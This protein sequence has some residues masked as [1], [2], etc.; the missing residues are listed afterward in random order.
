[1][2]TRAPILGDL[3][4]TMW[5]GD[6]QQLDDGTQVQPLVNLLLGNPQT[7]RWQAT[8]ACRDWRSGGA[9]VVGD[10]MLIQLLLGTRAEDVE[11]YSEHSSIGVLWI[12]TWGCW[13]Y[14]CSGSNN[15]VYLQLHMGVDMSRFPDINSESEVMQEICTQ[16]SALDIC[17]NKLCP[18]GGNGGVVGWR[19]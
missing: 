7:I 5:R 2:V 4:G 10:S 13:P 19:L 14:R 12:N 1:M 8:R 15:P 11:E 16:G 17:Y 9:D 6:A 3:M 18:V